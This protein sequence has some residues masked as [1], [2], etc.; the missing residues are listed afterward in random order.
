MAVF[1]LASMSLVLHYQL[2]IILHDYAMQ[3]S[4]GVDLWVSIVAAIGSLRDAAAWDYGVDDT[5]KGTDTY[6]YNT[7]PRNT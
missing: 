5:G 3:T 2:G 4:H 7:T 1:S 6:H